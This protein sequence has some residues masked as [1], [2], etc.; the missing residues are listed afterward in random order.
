MNHVEA[1]ALNWLAANTGFSKDEI[2]FHG[3]SS[4]DFT[5]PDGQGYEIKYRQPKKRTITLYPRQW[6]ELLRHLRAYILVF[7]EGTEPEAIIPMDELP[8]GTRHWRNFTIYCRDISFREIESLFEIPR[9]RIWQ[10][11]NNEIERNNSQTVLMDC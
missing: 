1:K 4:P 6:L 7:G 8:L 10:L 9:S 3:S 5:T 2:K 11:L